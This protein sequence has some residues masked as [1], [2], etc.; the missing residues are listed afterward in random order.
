MDARSLSHVKDIRCK[1]RT[2][3]SSHSSRQGIDGGHIH[4]AIQLPQSCSTIKCV[5][6]PLGKNKASATRSHPVNT[7]VMKGVRTAI[8][9]QLCPTKKPIKAN[10]AAS[11]PPSCRPSD[12]PPAA[13]HWQWRCCCRQGGCSSRALAA[14]TAAQTVSKLLIC[15]SLVL[16]HRSAAG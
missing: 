9:Q 4:A 5:C 11:I 8:G 3:A 10:H 1:D 7:V 6:M 16:F 12:P 13:A 14:A 2:N 15:C